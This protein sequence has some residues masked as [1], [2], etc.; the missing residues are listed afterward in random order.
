MP[1]QGL[2]VAYDEIVGSKSPWS[3][4]S[5]RTD[6]RTQRE[7]DV[8]F[9]DVATAL[10]QLRGY[11]TAVDGGAG[12]AILTRYL[13]D[14]HPRFTNLWCVSAEAYGHSVPGDRQ[15]QTALP[16]GPADR[17]LKARIVA[18]YAAPK[19]LV[20]DDTQAAAAGGEFARFLE[21][22]GKGEGDYLSLPLGN[23]YWAQGPAVNTV[24]PAGLGKIT[25][26]VGLEWVWHDIPR[27]WVDVDFY[28]LAVGQVNDRAFLGVPRHC[29]LLTGVDY[30]DAFGP[31]GELLLDVHFHVRV[32]MNLWTKQLYY[33]DGL[34]YGVTRGMANPAP[35]PTTIATPYIADSGNAP[36]NVADGTCL[37]DEFD[38]A[39]LF[40]LRVT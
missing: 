29:L 34:F 32:N 9:S 11:P 33:G 16:V 4:S 22:R 7:F 14:R 35:P 38:F 5:S 30:E 17:Y 40:T 37:Y 27:E 13:P 39:I 18:E 21:V 2:A 1:G 26:F 8:A 15:M 23:L 10:S 36:P 12:P 3:F 25:P 28:S 19:Y 31:L 6:V 20:L 24:F